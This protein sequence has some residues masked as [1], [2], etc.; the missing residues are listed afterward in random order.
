MAGS[1][2]QLACSSAHLAKRSFL[3]LAEQMQ[4]C[5]NQHQQLPELPDR[6]GHTVA[7]SSSLT[8]QLRLNPTNNP[9]LQHQAALAS[10]VRN[11]SSTQKKA[12]QQ[13]PGRFFVFLH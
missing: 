3:C 4:R 12:P 6:D 11:L 13:W 9:T 5:S 10:Q 1:K 7:E 2:Q 8:E